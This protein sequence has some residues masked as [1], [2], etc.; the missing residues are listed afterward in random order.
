METT[1][2]YLTLTAEDVPDKATQYKC[3]PPVRGADNRERLWSAVVAGDI[4]L[5]V[6]DHSPCTADLK[7]PGEMGF[8]EAWGGI[9]SLK[10]GLALFWTSASGRGLGLAD[11][12][13]LMA[14]EPA[15][16]ARLDDRSG[17]K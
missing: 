9:S 15:K 10:F 16:L 7:R 6:S 17:G 8:M 13:R 11:L 5:V 3:C 1:H 2:H 12:N 14:V 4:D